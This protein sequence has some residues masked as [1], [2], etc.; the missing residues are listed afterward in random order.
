MHIETTRQGKLV[1]N[2]SGAM[3]Y[4]SF[5]PAPIPEVLPL[6]LGEQVRFTLA[7]CSRKLGEIAGMARFVPNAEMYLTMYVRKEAL[8][9]AQ[10][11]GTQCTFDDV[12]DPNNSRAV[13]REVAEVVSY[14][15][16]LNYAVKRMHEMS[17]CT[18]LLRETHEVLLKGTRGEN[19]FPDE[20]R[21]TQN[22]IGPAGCMLREA[23]YV[24]PNVDDMRTALF[25]LDAFLNDREG[26]DP[27]VKAALAHYQFETIHPFC[28]GNGRLG[29]LLI[30]LSLI[31][32][33]ALPSAVFYPS[34]QL[35]RR[36]SE[37]YQRLTDVRERGEYEAWVE[38]F[39]DCLLASA[40]DA[41][42]SMDKLVRVHA[43]AEGLVRDRLGRSVSNG[44]RLLELAEAHPILDVPFATKV[45]GVSRGTAA[46]LMK[47][48]CEMGIFAVRDDGRQRYRIYTFESYL[49]VLRADTDPL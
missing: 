2:L 35:K 26:I 29:R 46:T 9:S 38:F 41:V 45:L 3:A 48:F 25:D 30:T 21:T 27:I 22:W 11:E 34:Y 19:K 7:A 31:N 33:H 4:Q 32:D 40:E 1:S 17:L 42:A 36:R 10:I 5:R 49:E 13:H 16:A 6:H 43:A 24:S 23:P 15:N 39:A 28:D 20:V 18:R 37:Y 44:L 12:L 8:L 14:V 47:E